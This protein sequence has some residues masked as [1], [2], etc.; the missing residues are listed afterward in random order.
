MTLPQ[1]G[2]YNQ[3]VTDMAKY[4][5]LGKQAERLAVL[6]A[7]QR[8]AAEQ[9][10]VAGS[11]GFN[12]G[13][14]AGALYASNNLQGYVAQNK[15][16]YYNNSGMYANG[17]G[18]D[19]GVTRNSEVGLPQPQASVDSLRDAQTSAALDAEIAKQQYNA[20]NGLQ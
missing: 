18:V 4:A 15:N 1:S 20:A 11:Q 5:N 12:E 8:K 16:D 3:S 19:R 7:E 13:L 6:Q 14:A 10:T 9:A 17:T 2:L